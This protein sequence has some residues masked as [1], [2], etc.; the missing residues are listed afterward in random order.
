MISELIQPVDKANNTLT[1]L[2]QSGKTP[3]K[4][5]SWV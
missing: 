3:F 5:V 4:I 2:L 1:Y